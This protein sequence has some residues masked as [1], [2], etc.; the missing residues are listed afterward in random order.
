MK[1]AQADLGSR[2]DIARAVEG[3]HTVYLVTNYWEYLSREI[4]VGQG[5]AV[6]D[7]AKAAGVKHLIYSSI[8]DV[9]IASNGRLR[10][11]E[12]FDGKAEVERYI[13]DSGVP[14][15]FVMAGF[16]MSNFFES[17]RKGDDGSFTLALPVS[18]SKA[19]IPVFDAAGDSGE[20][21]AP[22]SLKS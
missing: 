19:R 5:K 6:T 16:F 10:H 15:T 18:G 14:G 20:Y 17:I 13:R 12:H 8:I 11:L 7:A 2:D 3:S 22:P 21:L 1:E 4:E 9:T